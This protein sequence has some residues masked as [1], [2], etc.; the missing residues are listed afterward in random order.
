VG[1]GSYCER[2]VITGRHVAPFASLKQVQLNGS[3]LQN[4]ILYQLGPFVGVSHLTLKC[5]RGFCP[6]RS[7]DLRAL[8]CILDSISTE[9]A[10]TAGQ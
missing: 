9:D 5:S 4:A 3:P 1:I 10:R 7:G 8:S 2:I 6:L